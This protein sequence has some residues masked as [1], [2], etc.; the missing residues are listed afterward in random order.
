MGSSTGTGQKP[1]S[2]LLVDDHPM[3]RAGIRLCLMEQEDMRC[4]GEA[5]NGEEGIAKTIELSPDIVLMDI[6]MPVMNGLEATGILQRVAPKT[7]VIALTMHDSKHYLTEMTRVG[8]RG[9]VLKD[10]DPEELMKVIRAVHRSDSGFSH[11]YISPGVG[12][13]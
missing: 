5:S 8:A 12:V 9:Y 1:I 7:K 2:I 3:I 6:S 11:P 4:V 10:A 13:K